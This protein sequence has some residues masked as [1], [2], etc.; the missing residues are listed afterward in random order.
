MT[1]TFTPETATQNPDHSQTFRYWAKQ[2]RSIFARFPSVQSVE[3]VRT[4]RKTD[5]K[6][7]VKD[8]PEP[9][10]AVIIASTGGRW[11]KRRRD[12]L[13]GARGTTPFRPLAT[14]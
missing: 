2:A 13:P 12:Y 6:R 5:A 11:G 3:V 14:A 9:G 4:G 1:L 7:L 10:W 8:A